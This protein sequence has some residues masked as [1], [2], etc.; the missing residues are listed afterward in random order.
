MRT[1]QVHLNFDKVAQRTVDQGVAL[2]AYDQRRNCALDWLT[3]IEWDGNDRLA[4]LLPDGFG[5]ERTPYTMAVGRCFV[6]GM[7]ARILMPGCQLDYMPVF[8]GAQGI[9]KSRALRALGGHWYA[10]AM[11][12]VLS[13]DFYLSLSGKLLI[14]V[15]EF[16][17][18][19]RADVMAIKAA[20][21]RPTDRYRI[22]YERHACDHPRQCA[23]AATT[24][25]THWNRDQTGG[26]R[27]WPVRCGAIDVELIHT[28][29]DQLF[30][31]ARTRVQRGEL[32]WDVP[33]SDTVHEQAKRYKGDHASRDMQSFAYSQTHP[34]STMDVVRHGLGL[35]GERALDQRVAERVEAQ[36]THLGF[37]AVHTL[38]GI[39]PERHWLPMARQIHH[40]QPQGEQEG[41]EHAGD[42]QDHPE[43]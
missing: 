5:T 3:A 7:A 15:A 32:W 2:Y 40:P 43:H 1:L 18:F 36:L 38:N 27:F 35:D 13:K 16:H 26:R 25:E 30:A 11:E 24:N 21:T 8:E 34:F 23:F 4:H 37:R 10:E 42:D 29:R 39:G 14:E 41:W 33:E 28:Q 12:S 17:A 31:E 22:P 19:N 20:I 6:M 9:H